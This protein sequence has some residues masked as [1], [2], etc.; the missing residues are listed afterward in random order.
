MVGLG[1]IK[2]R[3]F[4]QVWWMPLF[5]SFDETIKEKFATVECKGQAFEGNLQTI[6]PCL[7][8]NAASSFGIYVREEMATQLW[9]NVSTTSS[10][11]KICSVDIFRFTVTRAKHSRVAE[12]HGKSLARRSFGCDDE[13]MRTAKLG[14]ALKW[15]NM[16]KSSK[17]KVSS[18][19][20]F[21][22]WDFEVFL[23]LRFI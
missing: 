4:G 14:Q 1:V 23:R 20:E 7:M 15:E 5:S 2:I 6:W 13:D 3:L 18:T 21:D 8:G 12:L 10:R 22:N 9:Y 16:V 19:M 17:K 11:I